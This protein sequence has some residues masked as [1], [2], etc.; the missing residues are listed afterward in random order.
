MQRIP[1]TFF[2]FLLVFLFS[3]NHLLQRERR[4]SEIRDLQTA[5][6]HPS[7]A[8]WQNCQVDV[9]EN[10][11]YSRVELLNWGWEILFTTWVM[12]LASTTE[13]EHCRLHSC[14]CSCCFK[15]RP[16]DFIWFFFGSCCRFLLVQTAVFFNM[17][18]QSTLKRD[19]A[20]ISEISTNESSWHQVLV[21]SWNQWQTNLGWMW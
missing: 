1:S 15:I 7:L 3:N 2:S 4:K 16:C 6:I 11:W 17:L 13:F 21:P 5:R 8:T 10:Y 18:W 9:W 19:S 14:Y 12:S 20:A